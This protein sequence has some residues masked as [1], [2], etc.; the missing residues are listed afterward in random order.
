MVVLQLRGG[1]GAP[2][3]VAGSIQRV[4]TAA[5]SEPVEA[6][7]SPG[8]HQGVGAGTNSRRTVTETR[9]TANGDRKRTSNGAQTGP[10]KITE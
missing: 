6:V 3:R 8:S 5:V 10:G 9:L 7:R 1:S 2:D 4:V